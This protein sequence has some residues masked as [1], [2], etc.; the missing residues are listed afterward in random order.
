MGTPS[1]FTWLES[2]LP[3]R[4][5]NEAEAAVLALAHDKDARHLA[6]RIDQIGA[7][8]ELAAALRADRRADLGLG[9]RRAGGRNDNLLPCVGRLQNHVFL[10]AVHGPA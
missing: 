1:R 6:Q 4:M 5:N 10:M 8:G 9:E 7:V 2:E 3:P